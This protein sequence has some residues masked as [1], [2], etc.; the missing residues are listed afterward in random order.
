[1]PPNSK[2]SADRIRRKKERPPYICLILIFYN[3]RSLLRSPKYLHFRAFCASSVTT[4]VTVK[5]KGTSKTVGK[6]SLD[7]SNQSS[8]ECEKQ[9]PVQTFP[10]N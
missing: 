8:V 2:I 5:L 1:M 6:R 4:V 3:Q 7:I 9:F 10:H